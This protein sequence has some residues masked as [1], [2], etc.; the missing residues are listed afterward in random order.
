MP[1]Q[2][3]YTTAKHWVDVQ[4]SVGGVVTFQP[5]NGGGA[6]LFSQIFAAQFTAENN[7]AVFTALPVTA[8][9]SISGDLKTILAN[10]GVGTVLGVLGAT[11]L[12]APDGTKVHAHI[13]GV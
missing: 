2:T 3:F 11:I 7:S 13:I 8:L 4:T 12:A 10:V 6:A 5:V 1:A 9:K